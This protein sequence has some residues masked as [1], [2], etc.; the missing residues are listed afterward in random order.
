MKVVYNSPNRSH[1]YHYALALHRAKCLQ[2]F[3]SGFPRFSPRAPLVDLSKRLVRRDFVQTLYMVSLKLRIPGPAS[4]FLAHRS[5]VYLDHCSLS[6][7]EK[8]DLFLF[9]NGAGLTTA[10]ALKSQRAISVCEVVNSHV[11]YQSELLREEFGG[12][13]LDYTEPY[14]PEFS[15]R[16]AEYEECDYILGPSEF[17]LNSFRERGFAENRLLKNPYGMPPLVKKVETSRDNTDDAFRILYVGQISVRKGL[18]Y[19]VQAFR[20]FN[21]PGKELHLVGPESAPTGLESEQIPDE[22]YF[23]GVLKG[24]SLAQMYQRASVFVLPSIEEGLA[25]VVGE[26]LS[27]GIPVVATGNTGADELFVDGEGGFLVPIRDSRAIL[28]RMI[29]LA[30]DKDL[31]ETMSDSALKR[32][33]ELNGWEESGRSLVELLQNLAE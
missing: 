32:S 28:E 30:D 33:R 12:L 26:A 7:A 31:R 16:L 23:H 22:V 1:H 20:E 11:A 3:I 14:P 10:R 13:G 18:R 24:E 8:A 6:Y 9:Y 17:V 5:K 4:R 2:A 21:H 27:F 29:L 25:L 19:L 15:R